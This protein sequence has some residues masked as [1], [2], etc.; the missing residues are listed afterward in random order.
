MER[1]V[2]W[3]YSLLCGLLLLGLLITGGIYVSRWH[4]RQA[5][6]YSKSKIC[7]FSDVEI[8]EKVAPL[9]KED[10]KILAQPFFFLSEGKQSTV[11]ESA[12]RKYVIKFFKK[13]KHKHHML[14]LQESVK[15]AVLARLMVP[16]E[17]AM[18]AL[19]IQQQTL[20]MP[21]LTL[22]NKKGKI[23]KRS[24]KSTPFMLQRK[25]GSFKEALLVLVSEKK[26]TQA[27]SL[28]QSVFILLSDCRQKGI[29]DLDGSL[30]RNGN[31]GVVDGKTVLIDVGK[32]VVVKDPKRQTLHDIN[33][34]KPLLSW[35]ELACPELVPVYKSCQKKYQER[36]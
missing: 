26:M 19:S 2:K 5:R 10:L 30:I 36:L 6:L 12:D 13:Q 1:Y 28:L 31:L 35:L 15:G 21:T 18:I 22:L 25:A 24:L 27:A 4:S 20:P 17:T 9:Q 11:Y 32:L 34:L 3:P 33:R 23:E 29:L 16:H 14:K 8:R 7:S